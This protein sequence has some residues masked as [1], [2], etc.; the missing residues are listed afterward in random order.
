[1]NDFVGRSVEAQ[2]IRLARAPINTSKVSLTQAQFQPIDHA[3]SGLRSRSV[4]ITAITIALPFLTR[5][6]MI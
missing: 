2:L 3:L 5:W 1:M 6:L 4:E